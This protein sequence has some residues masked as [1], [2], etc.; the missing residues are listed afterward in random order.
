MSGNCLE[1]FDALTSAAP[2]PAI[3]DDEETHRGTFFEGLPIL[4][5]SDAGRFENA[6]FLC[7]IGSPKSY[8]SRSFIVQGL[9]LDQSRYAT[10]LHPAASMS[11][12]GWIG[13]GSVL[14]AG[15]LVTSNA[16]IGDHVL[17][18]PRTILHHDVDVGAFSILGAGV[19]VAGGVQ[20]GN[21]CYIGSGSTIRDGV[22]IGDGALIGLGSVVVRD[23]AAGTVVAG[24]PARPIASSLA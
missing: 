18:L 5:L 2:I 9:S 14:Y 16:R 7:L 10:F 1:L 19:I 12:F 24:N 8:R 13:R 23:V 11:R 6:Q 20:I 17:V 22:R 15:V 4:P 21:G 3:L